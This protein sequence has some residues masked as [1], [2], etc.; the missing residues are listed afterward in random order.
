MFRF[1]SFRNPRPVDSDVPGYAAAS[2]S[3]ETNHYLCTK[4]F[5]REVFDWVQ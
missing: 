5:R 3:G 2:L 1:L 4:L